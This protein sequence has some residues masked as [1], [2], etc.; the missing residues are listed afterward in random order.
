MEDLGVVLR[1]LMGSLRGAVEQ[2][3]VEIAKFTEKRNKSAGTRARKQLQMVRKLA[4]EVRD[5]IQRIRTEEL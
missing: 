2:A 1:D 4:K 5:E 3:E